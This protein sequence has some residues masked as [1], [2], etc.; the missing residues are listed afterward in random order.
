MSGVDKN[1]FLISIYRTSIRSKKWTLHLFTHSLGM[2]VTNAWLEHK[3]TA[4]GLG[5]PLHNTM[6][7]VNFRMNISEVLILRG[8]E[9]LK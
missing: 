5:I 4:S 2:A 8:Q 9:T 7:L 3:A 6:N 1:D